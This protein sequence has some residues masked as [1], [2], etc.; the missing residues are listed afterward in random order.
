MCSYNLFQKTLICYGELLIQSSNGDGGGGDV[1]V[2]V[3][4]LRL[5]V[6]PTLASQLLFQLQGESSE[7]SFKNMSICNIPSIFV[8]ILRGMAFNWLFHS[9]PMH[10]CW[11]YMLATY[12]EWSVSPNNNTSESLFD[13]YYFF[14]I[15]MPKINYIVHIHPKQMKIVFQICCFVFLR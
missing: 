5:F 11:L 12:Q 15:L 1:C 13:Y 3:F 7:N 10:N 6:W 9:S 2:C 14:W 4:T 8:A